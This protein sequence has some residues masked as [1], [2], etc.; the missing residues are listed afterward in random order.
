MNA[1]KVRYSPLADPGEISGLP[2]HEIFPKTSCECKSS[3]EM[4]E[5]SDETVL[6]NVQA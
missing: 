2:C 6:N 3:L 4:L 1:C 5:P